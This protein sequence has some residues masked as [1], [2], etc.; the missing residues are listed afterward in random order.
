M[1]ETSCAKALW[2]EEAWAV[3]ATGRSSG[4]LGANSEQVAVQPDAA[5]AD[6]NS[7]RK[8]LKA[9]VGSWHLWDLR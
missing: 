6:R 5:G 2:Q 4:G 1:K 7:A 9:M 3:P 8:A